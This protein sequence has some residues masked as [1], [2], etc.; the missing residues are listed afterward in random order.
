MTTARI[1]AVDELIDELTKA[2]QIIR[3]ALNCLSS[4]G[5]RKFILRVCESGLD[6]EGISRANERAQL[7]ARVGA[8]S[9][10]AF[11]HSP[12]AVTN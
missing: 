4:E 8:N 5:K 6:G 3:I 1:D 9:A 12:R 11:A 10:P 2:H 7:L